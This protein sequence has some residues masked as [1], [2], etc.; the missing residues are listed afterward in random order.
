MTDAGIS[1]PRQYAR[2]VGFTLGVPHGFAI[3][4]DGSRVAFLRARSG[5]DRSTGLWVRDTATGAERLVADAEDL[6][7]GCEESLPAE[8]RARRERTRQ[9]AAGVVSFAVDE[10]VR[11][12]AF[13]LSGRLFV[14]DLADL[15]GITIR[16]LAV[17]G[18]VLDPR[19]D[20]TGTH[21]GYVADGALRVVAADGAGDRVVAVPEGENVTY[22]LAEF[23]AAEEMYRTRGFW[24]SPDGRQLL[25]ARV[26]T[27]PVARWHLSD[28]AHPDR[29]PVEVAY[30]M[31]GTANADVSVVLARLDG[32][33]T[34]VGWD[35]SDAPYL[36]AAH[37]SRGGP[38]LLQ[39]A[40][41]DQ[42]TM[43]VL[44]VGEDGTAQ[45]IC[46]DTDPDWVDVV[47][48]TPAWTPGG[49]LVR[50]V[51]RDGAY[52]LM[53]GEDP[54]TPVD[55]NVVAVLDV[56]DDVLLTAT[57]ANPAEVH[58]YTAGPNGT[59]RLT[60]Q[61]GVHQAARRGDVVI[62]S[63]QS[64]G[65][66][67]PR[68]QSWR[69]GEQIGEIASLAETPVLTPEVT[70]LTAGAHELRCALLLPRGHQRGSARLPVL[71]DPYGGPAAQRVVCARNAYLTPQWFADQGF[72]VLIA[73]GRGTPGRGPDWDRLIHYDEATPNLEDQV[74]AL[75]A[76]AAAHP[77]L[78][79]TRVGIRG[80]SHG[81]YL[82][83][84]AV[85]R[86]PDV[87]HTAVAGAPVTEQRL[88]DTFYTE[89]Y[90]GH[91]DRHPDAYAHNSLIDDA[92]KLERPLML[93]HGLADDNVVVA[94]TLRLS[95]ALLAAG[96]PHTVLLLSGITH[97]AR[98]EEVAENLMLLQV[99]F[100]KRTLGMTPG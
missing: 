7:S 42:R 28:P 37:W 24:W 30:P 2:T 74:E 50:V 65:W 79:L 59:V 20:P 22:G 100:L 76:A 98:Q 29:P 25:A 53:I 31:A 99:E 14:A 58:V 8:E 1:F 17:A 26:D 70:F 62:T 94:H 83:A 84:L 16:E 19:P 48:G 55:L 73:D 27:T 87:F 4:P 13:A 66:F 12:A 23:V 60:Q 56:D 91:P 41:R 68:V 54:I 89:R 46:E 96:R 6:L 88:Y 85:L 69:T 10:G 61:P 67:G 64:L 51:A 52:R 81:G 21:I 3:A 82:A 63:S 45:R 97:M 57:G 43:R 38:A 93:I 36:T 78:D 34:P 80:W 44:A 47:V 71:C 32:T 72:A 40:S 77:D 18:S 9:A 90:L 11:I 35:S 75:H 95:S 15:D 39:V 5:A 49:E 92:P 86:R 33:L